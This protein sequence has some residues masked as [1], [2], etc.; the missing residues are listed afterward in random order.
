MDSEEDGHILCIHTQRN[1]SEN[2]ASWLADRRNETSG[3]IKGREFLD[4]L[5]ASFQATASYV[6]PSRDHVSI[7][8]TADKIIVYINWH[9][10]FW[11]VK[12]T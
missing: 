7:S 4:S 2:K 11:E 3:S 9:S 8:Y 10:I 5:N 1:S 6:I 12:G